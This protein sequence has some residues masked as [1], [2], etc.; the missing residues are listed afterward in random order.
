MHMLKADTSLMLTLADSG[1]KT[2]RLYELRFRCATHLKRGFVAI[3]L[4]R[5]EIKPPF[6]EH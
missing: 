2:C 5:L 3:E 1:Y 6:S 4:L